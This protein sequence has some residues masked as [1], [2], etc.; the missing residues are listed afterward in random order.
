M[1]QGCVFEEPTGVL[2]DGLGFELA[3]VVDAGSC[4]QR[5]WALCWAGH[6]CSDTSE[7]E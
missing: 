2:D 1:W 5:G 4:G 3:I 6:N 7:T